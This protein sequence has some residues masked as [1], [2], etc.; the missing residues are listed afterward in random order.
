MR[1]KEEVCLVID[2][3]LKNLIL[4]LSERHDTSISDIV[5]RLLWKGM[6][7]ERM[8]ML[9]NMFVGE[10]D[11][12]TIEEMKREFDAVPELDEAMRILKESKA[13]KLLA[14]F[15]QESEPSEDR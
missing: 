12:K 10:I 4:T 3:A 11:D 14:S 15:L 5:E 13:G 2:V 8:E 7:F 6:E 9:A 1:D